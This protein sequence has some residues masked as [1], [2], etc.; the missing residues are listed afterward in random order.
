MMMMT[1]MMICGV[2]I[3]S[4]VNAYCQHKPKTRFRNETYR[5]IGVGSWC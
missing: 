4:T 5:V 1:M 3:D 2:G